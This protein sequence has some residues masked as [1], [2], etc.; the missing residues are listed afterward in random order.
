[1]EEGDV[2]ICKCRY[3]G[4]EMQIVRET[5]ASYLIVCPNKECPKI[6]GYYGRIYRENITDDDLLLEAEDIFLN[7]ID[8]STTKKAEKFMKRFVECFLNKYWR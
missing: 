1:M 7:V 2:P 8:E 5:G 3:C 6:D 4:T